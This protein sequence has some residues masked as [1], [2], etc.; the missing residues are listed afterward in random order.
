MLPALPRLSSVLLASA[1]LFVS[2]PAHAQDATPL[3]LPSINVVAPRQAPERRPRRR[4]Q[5]KHRKI[6]R[7]QAIPPIYRAR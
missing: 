4:S 5:C 7:H 2:F 6:P 1:T 3:S